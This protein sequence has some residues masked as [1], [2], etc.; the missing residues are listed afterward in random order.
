MAREF[1]AHE[2]QW[3]WSLHTNVVGYKW[4]FRTKYNYDGFVARYKA[5]LVAKGYY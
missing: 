1:N 3:T 2:E 4:V 5:S